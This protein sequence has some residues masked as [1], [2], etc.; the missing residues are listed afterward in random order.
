MNQLNVPYEDS[1]HQLLRGIVSR[2]QR[3]VITW[4][5]LPNNL[6][7]TVT[8]HPTD[9]GRLIGKAGANAKAIQTVWNKIA[10][11]Y[12][13]RLRL[14]IA[15]MTFESGQSREFQNDQTW[16][17]DNEV[18][19]MVQDILG[20]IWTKEIEVKAIPHGDATHITFSKKYNA[21]CAEEDD[22]Y[23]AMELLLN[24]FGNAQGH[25]IFF[26]PRCD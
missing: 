3:L 11:C 16:N 24:A 2:P 9:V 4:Q 20:H 15:G 10:D 19:Q 25:R 23:A 13:D 1:L 22:I 8:P 7:C 12:D 17:R 6:L 5:R 21:P 14:T 18:C 26:N